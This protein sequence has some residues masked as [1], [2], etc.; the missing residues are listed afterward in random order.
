MKSAKDL[1]NLTNDD[2]EYIL[3]SFKDSN[4]KQQQPLKQK[5]SVCSES[6][7]FNSSSK[8]S[9]NTSTTNRESNKLLFH[10][11]SFNVGN[12]KTLL[13]AKEKETKVKTLSKP[14]SSVISQSGLDHHGK[15]KQNQNNYV[16]IKS[17]FGLDC[18]DFFGVFDAYF[19]FF[20]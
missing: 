19:L 9:S 16:L 14:I 5:S 18:V 1:P 15:A 8:L 20:L 10:R 11:N 13:K 6:N 3:G 12:E 2:K 7:H 17:A 4:T